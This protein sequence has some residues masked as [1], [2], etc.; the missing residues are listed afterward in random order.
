MPA[1]VTSRQLHVEVNDHRLCHLYYAAAVRV[2][3][4]YSRDTLA[5]SSCAPCE[6]SEEIIS[7][8]MAAARVHDQRQADPLHGERL[9]SYLL[10]ASGKMRHL[11][12]AAHTR[13]NAY[14]VEGSD[15]STKPC[16]KLA[17][18]IRTAHSAGLRTKSSEN[19]S[20]VL[21]S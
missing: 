7:I 12:Q 3:S 10:T 15:V 19:R 8:S 4:K 13:P 6:C 11:K 21:V 16:G 1:S 17:F 5:R 14:R 2:E 9:A 18:G 20:L